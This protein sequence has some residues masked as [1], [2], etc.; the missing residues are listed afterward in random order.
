MNQSERE[1]LIK[2]L[3]ESHA[4]NLATAIDNIPSNRDVFYFLPEEFNN[5]LYITTPNESRKVIEIKANPN[6]SFVTVPT[7]AD[8]GVVT[9]NSATA[10]VSELGILDVCPL[11]AKQIPDWEATVGE[12]VDDFIVIEVSFDTAKIFGD[13]GIF[14]LVLTEDEN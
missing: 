7:D 9:S 14:E 8:N 10:K 12:A 4:L 3:S 5:M 6:V 2:Y 1:L 11:I 13:Q